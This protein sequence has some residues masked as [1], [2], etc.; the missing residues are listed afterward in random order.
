MTN[1][2]TNTKAEKSARTKDRIIAA[3]RYV[4]ARDGYA[5]AALSDIITEAGVTTGAVYHH[6]GDKKGLFQAVA[7]S[8]EQEILDEVSNRILK[9]ESTWDVFE[10][11]VVETLEI[12]AR[13]DIQR[14]VFR[15]APTVIGFREWRDIEIK[16]AFGIMRATVQDLA[17]NGH[18]NTNAPDMTAQII[19]G[20]LMEAAHSVSEAKNKKAALIDAKATV[21]IM[22]RALSTKP[23]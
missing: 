23:I 6:F 10:S 19:L 5:V 20:A 18:L 16:Y 13:P 21:T 17:K 4:F 14:I 15:E 22:L 8:L 12:C 1:T 2:K 11:G 3:A 9:A 7:E